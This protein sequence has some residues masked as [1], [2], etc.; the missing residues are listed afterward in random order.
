MGSSPDFVPGEVPTAA[1]WNADFASKQDNIGYTPL[2][3]DANLSDLTDVTQAQVNLGVYPPNPPGTFGA[4]VLSTSGNPTISEP[5]AMLVVDNTIPVATTVFLPV[6]PGLNESVVVKDGA[7]NAATYNITVSGNGNTIDGNPSYVINSNYGAAGFAWNGSFWSVWTLSQVGFTGTVTTT[8]VQGLSAITITSGQSLTTTQSAALSLSTS[9][10]AGL[11]SFVLGT[12]QAAALSLT[13]SQIQNLSSVGLSSTQLNGITSLGSLS[14]NT[15]Q[16]AALSLSTSQIVG[17]ASMVLSSTQWSGLTQAP[18]LGFTSTQVAALTPVSFNATQLASISQLPNLALTTTQI[19]GISTTALAAL[20]VTQIA[21]LAQA[22]TLAVQQELYTSAIASGTSD[23]LTAS[24]T[25][26]ITT[27]TLAG[28]AVELTIRAAQANVTTNPTFTPNSG[29]VPAYTIVKGNNL[30]LVPGDIAGVSHWIT[31]QWDGVLSKWVLLNPA[32]GVTASSSA[33]GNALNLKISIPSALATTSVSADEVPVKQV[34]GGA[35]LTLGNYW[36]NL[37]LATTGAGAMDTGT[38]PVSG[39][40]NVYAIAKPSVAVAAAPYVLVPRAGAANTGSDVGPYQA[41]LTLNNVTTS[42]SSMQDVEAFVFNGS[43]AYFSVAYNA[44]LGQYLPSSGDFAMGCWFYPTTTNNGVL[45]FGGRNNN[46]IVFYVSSAGIVSAWQGDVGALVTATNAFVLNTWNYVQYYRS[47]TNGVLTLFN[48]TTSYNYTCTDSNTY[49][50]GNS[51]GNYG[52]AQ[53]IGGYAGG[54]GYFNGSIAGCWVSNSAA[55]YVSPPANPIALTSPLA[56]VIATIQCNTPTYTGAYL[57]SGYTY[58]AL[59]ATIPTNSSS[60]FQPGLFSG[61]TWYWQ[62]KQN[63]ANITSSP[64]TTYAS[65]TTTTCFPVN[66]KTIGGVGGAPTSVAAAFA[67]S[68]DAS[69]TGELVIIDANTG[70]LVDSFYDAQPFSNFPILTAGTI[71][72]K[73]YS[74]TYT[75]RIDIDSYTI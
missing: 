17:L 73:S 60:Q 24:F 65:I 43:N 56:S 15:T 7:G 23:A 27:T 53:L 9:Q 62:V 33:L 46:S 22:T 12:T 2:N 31:L 47:G 11:Q 39:F 21:G 45:F 29:V 3:A 61:R 8:Q 37:N 49:Q 70:L 66:A 1:Q 6:T 75:V 26:A 36:G 5:T 57:P 54:A 10:V 14:L 71:Y 32:F 4:I 58:S 59:I 69:G 72:Y 40:V 67:M 64:S 63:L 18:N 48:G 13:T 68:A 25:P 20:T 38:A 28:G 74:T 35:A 41:S 44:A 50:N 52:G 51:S 55:P 19:L 34:L 16:S 42:A 30:A